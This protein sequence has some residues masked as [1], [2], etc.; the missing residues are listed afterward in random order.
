M[1]AGPQSPH[2]PSTINLAGGIG[3]DRV[4]QEVLR[5]QRPSHVKDPLS[6]ISPNSSI[7]ASPFTTVKPESNSSLRG[8][9]P[10]EA[11]EVERPIA[12]QWTGPS[13]F[14]TDHISLSNA[15]YPMSS[16][17]GIGSGDFFPYTQ[18]GMLYNDNYRIPYAAQYSISSC[19]R[20]YYGVNI[21]GLPKD[22]D[23]SESYPPAV[24]QIEPQKH[25]D[26]LPDHGMNDHLMQMRDDYEHH[27]GSLIKYKEYTGY[28]SSYSDLTRASTPSCDSPRHPLDL[29]GGDDA[30]IDK[31]Q[32]YAQLIYQALLQAD[33]HTMILRDIYDWFLKYTDKAAA[34]ETKGWQNSIRHNLSMNGVRCP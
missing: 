17:D 9:L 26:P 1:M 25:Y 23:M 22:V 32:P 13:D 11:M 16:Q 31:E 34:S 3:T 20:S 5:A 15:N 4:S 28:N 30:M 19:P 10:T 33:G 8:K 12:T 29:H 18:N 6:P 27:Y 14:S 7:E 21:N 24:Y 2:M